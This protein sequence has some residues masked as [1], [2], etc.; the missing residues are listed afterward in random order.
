MHPVE[1]EIRGEISVR[2]ISSMAKKL[3]SFGFHRSSTTRRTSVMSFGTV[4][5]IKN[6]RQRITG[7]VRDIVDIRCRITDGHAEVVGKIGPTNAANRVEISVPVSFDDLSR[8]AQ[9]FGA[10]PFF[11]KVGSK[12]TENFVK[13][14]ITVSL[15]RSPSGLAYIEIEK[16]ATRKSEQKNLAELHRLASALNVDIWKTR[17]AFLDFCNLLTERDDW[18]FTGTPAD[19]KRLTREIKKS[20]SNRSF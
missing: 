20:G 5:C 17:Q 12:I 11:T 6:D 18:I 16:M 4:T 1:L 10:M 9:L 7:K 13:D 19:L 2:N 15:V 3:L 8:F 14:D